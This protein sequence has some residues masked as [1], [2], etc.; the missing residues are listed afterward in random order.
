M[1]HPHVLDGVGPESVIGAVERVVAI[2]SIGGTPAELDAQRFFA[3]AWSAD[4]LEVHTWD[5]DLPALTARPD[6]PG[7]EVERTAGLGVVARWPGT[8]TGPSI[9]LLGHTDVVPPGDLAAW[10]RDPFL[11]HTENGRITGRGT[12]DMK[13]GLVAA[14]LA[15]RHLKQSGVS[16][17]GD[18][19]LAAVSGEEDGGLGTYA[20]LQKLD[21]LGWTVDSCV[22]PEPTDLDIVPANGGALTFR[23]IVR[24]AATHASRRSEGVSAIEKFLS[25]E[26]GTLSRHLGW[27]P[28]VAPAMPDLE[29]AIITDRTLTGEQRRIML[30]L[31]ERFRDE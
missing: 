16:L 28:V 2:P 22:I 25:L 19:I 15:V 4:G 6:F 30:A 9:M 8:A 1:N 10:S 3:D 24:G 18:V 29:A 11:P 14:W 27:V 13:A 21:E 7:M 12:A 17:P 20:L 5:L 31:V 23:L 26:P